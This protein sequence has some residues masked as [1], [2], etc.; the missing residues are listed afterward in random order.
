MMYHK[1]NKKEPSV[2]PKGILEALE[3]YNFN[4]QAGLCHPPFTHFL[5][6]FMQAKEPLAIKYLC[7]V[8][9]SG[10][11]YKFNNYKHRITKL[12]FLSLTTYF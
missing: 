11:K 3:L 4:I 10:I 5:L 1:Q 2:G 8:L 6:C 7:A 12:L 9:M